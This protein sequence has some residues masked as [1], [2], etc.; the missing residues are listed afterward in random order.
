MTK[1]FKKSKKPYFGVILDPFCPNL[2]KNE[3]SWK[4]GL[5]QFLDIPIIYYRAKIRK[6]YRTISEKNTELTDG[7]TNNGD[8]IGPL[9]GRGSNKKGLVLPNRIAIKNL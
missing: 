5:C 3:F 8:F 1:F 9:V 6:N 2:G 7:Q 4:K